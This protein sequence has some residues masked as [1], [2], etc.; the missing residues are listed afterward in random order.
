MNTIPSFTLLCHFEGYRWYIQF[1]LSKTHLKFSTQQYISMTVKSSNFHLH[2]I[3][4]SLCKLIRSLTWA[5]PNVFKGEVFCLPPEVSLWSRQPVDQTIRYPEDP[6]ERSGIQLTQRKCHLRAQ[7]WMP[8]QRSKTSHFYCFLCL[9]ESNK[10][11][12]ITI[13]CTTCSN[14]ERQ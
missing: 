5:H 10:S 14:N 11:D 9:A 3:G 1:S 13:S 12:E 6:M 2:P 4:L 7:D 8:H